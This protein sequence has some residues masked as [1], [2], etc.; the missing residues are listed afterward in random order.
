MAAAL[1]LC[2]LAWILPLVAGFLSAG[3]IA[4]AT[5]KMGASAVGPWMILAVLLEVVFS[6]TASIFLYKWI[7]PLLHGGVLIGLYLVHS[8]VQ[9]GLVGLMAFSTLVLFNR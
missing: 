6:L 7:S 1:R 2:F 8:I 5:S 4:G 3:I 9:L